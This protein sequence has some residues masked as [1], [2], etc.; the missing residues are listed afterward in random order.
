MRFLACPGSSEGPAWYSSLVRARATRRYAVCGVRVILEKD[1]L[2]P[3]RHQI[4]HLGRGQ[5]A[6][7][8]LLNPSDHQAS[9]RTIARHTR[10]RRTG[11]GSSSSARCSA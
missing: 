7:L 3:L 5:P 8:R 9:I 2:H 6:I 4:R 11:W 10:W 1:F